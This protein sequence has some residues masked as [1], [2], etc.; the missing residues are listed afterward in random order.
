[1][2]N[3]NLPSPEERQ[4]QRLIGTTLRTGVIVACAVA[5]VGGIAY[6]LQHGSDPMPDYT[7]FSYANPPAGHQAYTTLGGILG[8]LLHFSARSVIQTGVL[9]LLLTPI[10]RVLLSLFDFALRRDWLYT[11]I[12]AFVLA[13]IISNSLGGH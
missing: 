12:T 6:L 11:L 10:L 3:S 13:V 8:G 5:L 1:M 4:M 9:V 7:T 2:S